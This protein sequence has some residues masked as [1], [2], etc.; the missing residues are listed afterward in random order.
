MST[1]DFVNHDRYPEDPYI[2]ESVTICF[3]SKYRVTYIRKKMS[4]GGMFWGEITAGV[5]EHGKKKYLKS[6]S[7]DSAFLADDIK[8]FL[9][10]RHWE[11]KTEKRGGPVAQEEQSDNNLPF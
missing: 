6:F 11:K 10:G 3:D 5:T 2:A 7:Q 1:F 4:N 8:A 9:D